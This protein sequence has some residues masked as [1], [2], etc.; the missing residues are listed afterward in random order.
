M[1][2]NIFQDSFFFLWEEDLSKKRKTEE[3]ILTD[4][5]K[6]SI[7]DQHNKNQFYFCI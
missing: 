3:K 7:Q 2:K 5:V 1:N 6:I 4:I